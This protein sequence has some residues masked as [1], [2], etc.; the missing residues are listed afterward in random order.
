MSG[1]NIFSVPKRK[2]IQRWGGWRQERTETAATAVLLG[3]SL[4]VVVLR[5]R[6][7]RAVEA[8]EDAAMF[9]CGSGRNG[10]I[11]FH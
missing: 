9:M 11:R 1:F 4:V 8:E 6:R 10:G 3:A 7:I 5:D 2:G